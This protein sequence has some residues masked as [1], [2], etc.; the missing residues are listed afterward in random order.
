MEEVLQEWQRPNS[1]EGLCVSYLQP[2]IIGVVPR[3][4]RHS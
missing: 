3:F 2:T 4:K 1:M